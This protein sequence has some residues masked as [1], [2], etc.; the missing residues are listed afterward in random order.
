MSQGLWESIELTGVYIIPNRDGKLDPGSFFSDN[1]YSPRKIGGGPWDVCRPDSVLIKVSP[2]THCNKSLFSV[3]L[4]FPSSIPSVVF[5]SPTLLEPFS[6][7]LILSKWYPHLDICFQCSLSWGISSAFTDDSGAQA[8]RKFPIEVDLVL[9]V[10]FFPFLFYCWP[11]WASMLLDCDGS[12]AL[13]TKL[14]C[15]RQTVCCLSPWKGLPSFLSCFRMG[16]E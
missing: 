2:L 1:E 3:L 10:Y 5:S 7:I 12:L 14:K 11:V 15:T 6:G 8:P 13:V 4:V 9:E 16:K